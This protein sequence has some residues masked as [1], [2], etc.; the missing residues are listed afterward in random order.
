MKRE[1]VGKITKFT[2]T[3]EA[4]SQNFHV[5]ASSDLR[6]LSQVRILQMGFLF[7]HRT[8]S[9]FPGNTSKLISAVAVLW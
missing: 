1:I 7:L 4:P 3:Y 6:Y 2:L 8:A 9:K 5:Q